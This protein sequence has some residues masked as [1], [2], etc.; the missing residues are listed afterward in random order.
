MKYFFKT[1]TY[2]QQ[3]LTSNWLKRK[4]EIMTRDNFVCS[5]CLCDNFETR[6]EVHHVVYMKGKSAWEYPDHLL[7]TLCR[8]CHEEEHENKDIFAIEY[9]MSKVRKLLNIK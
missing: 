6:L 8:E 2:K 3:L 4:S 9:I 1:L 5:H 7:I